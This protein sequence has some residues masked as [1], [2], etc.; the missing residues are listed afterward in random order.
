MIIANIMISNFDLNVASSLERL[1]STLWEAETNI[2]VEITIKR[3]VQEET[4]ELYLWTGG[5]TAHRMARLC[6]VS[7]SALRTSREAVN[8]THISI[9]IYI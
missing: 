4:E 8:E 1:Q 3:K 7:H 6:Y 9:Y 2:E 5:R